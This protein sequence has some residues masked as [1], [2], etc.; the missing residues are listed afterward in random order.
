MNASALFSTGAGTA[1]TK[2]LFRLSRREAAVRVRRTRDLETDLCPH[3]APFTELTRRSED[4]V[5]LIFG[6]GGGA[7]QSSSIYR[8]PE[9]KAERE[10]VSNPSDLLPSPFAMDRECA[11]RRMGMPERQIRDGSARV[12]QVRRQA[13]PPPSLPSNKTFHVERLSAKQHVVDGTSKLRCQH[14]ESLSL[15]VLL[16][17]AGKVLLAGRV[18]PQKQG[19]RFGEGPLEMDVAHLPTCSLLDLPGRLMHAFDQTRVREKLLDAW[20]ALDVVDLVEQGQSEDLT[21]SWYGAQQKEACVVVL[22]DFMEQEQ[23]ELSDHLVVGGGEGDVDGDGHLQSFLV[24]VLDDVS[25]VLGLAD[26]LLQRREVVL[27]VGV[28]DVGEKLAALPGEE[29]PPAQK[30]SRR[31][32]LARIDVGLWQVSSAQ[33][34][35]DLG[36]VAAVV[37]GLSPMDRLHEE[38][39]AEHEGEAV[40]LA[41]VCYPVPA[42]EA[43]DGDDEVL[44]VGLERCEQ[45]LSVTGELSMEQGVSCLVEDAHVEAASV[46]VDSA[47]MPVLLGVKSHGGL[48][49][50][51]VLPP[52]QPTVWVGRRGPQISIPAYLL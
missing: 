9:M 22:A 27:S 5:Q 47:V 35:G 46:Q 16:L 38:G 6:V 32:H 10:R 37:L 48:L 2:H 13:H 49:G 28:L 8:D 1:C 11:L 50:R 39:M 43:L 44:L 51:R 34:R 19:R 23:L 33:Q 3:V 17:Q 26:A 42:E 14:A 45:R 41:Q 12:A 36:G 40:L 31:P 29:Q 21:D 20:K 30:I 15:P 4:R 7:E 52:R 25:P 24:E 18:G